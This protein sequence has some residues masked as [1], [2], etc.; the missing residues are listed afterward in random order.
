MSPSEVADAPDAGSI[1][2]T[3][4]KAR[5]IRAALDLFARHGVGGTSLQMIADEIGV[6]KAAVYHQYKTKD[7]IV[8]AAAEDELARLQAIID[9]AETE[10]SRKRAPDM[11]VTGIVDL[12]VDRRRTVSTILSDPVIADFFAEHETFHEVMHRLRRVLIDDDAGPEAGVRT[13]ILLAAISGAVMHP[14]VVDLDDD[15]LRAEL[16]RLARRFLGLHG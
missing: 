5:I 12:A 4:A 8:L 15:K 9:A 11:L 10:P 13:A 2:P 16:L 1:E 3:A 14:F 6:T 7:E